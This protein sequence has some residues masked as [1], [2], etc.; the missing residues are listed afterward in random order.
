MQYH[1]AYCSKCNADWDGEVDEPCL[2][3]RQGYRRTTSFTPGPISFGDEGVFT[4][5]GSGRFWQEQWMRTLQLF[6]KVRAIYESDRFPGEE[7][8]RATIETFF[9][10]CLHVGDWLWDDPGGRRSKEDVLALFRGDPA[11][12]ICRGF[13]NTVK[14]RGRDRDGDIEAVIKR[15]HHPHAGRP[16]TATVEWWLEG[17][18]DVRHTVDALKL[19]EDC[20]AT[21]KQYLKKE[22]VLKLSDVMR[23][24]DS[25]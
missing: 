6:E 9:L 15:V 21:W 16:A 22:P 25:F 23:R 18:E 19:A 1:L 5:Y 13:A 8:A 4:S 14:H 20:M 17:Q 3:C 24:R 11:L 2:V 7:V 12:G 10:N